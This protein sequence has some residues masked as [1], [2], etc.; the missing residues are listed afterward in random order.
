MN[1]DVCKTTALPRRTVMKNYFS[2][3]RNAPGRAP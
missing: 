2:R 1:K 3:E